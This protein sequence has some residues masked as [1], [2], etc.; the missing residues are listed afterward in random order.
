MKV[1]AGLNKDKCLLELTN[2]ELSKILGVWSSDEKI[3]KICEGEM[4]NKDI[5]LPSTY[6]NIGTVKKVPQQIQNV[7]KCFDEAKNHMEKALEYSQ[8][9]DLLNVK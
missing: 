9:I 8:K 4:N 2:N 1:I 5:E 7:I 3:K 6:D